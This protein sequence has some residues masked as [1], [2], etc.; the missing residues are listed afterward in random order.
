[1]AG[2]KDWEMS[3]RLQEDH[4]NHPASHLAA[5]VE[6]SDDAIISKDLEGRILSWNAGA[7]RV[8]GYSASEAIGQPMTIVLAPDRADEEDEILNHIRRGMRFEHFE[9]VRQRKDGH[10]IQV[11]LT[12]SPVRDSSG[13]IIGASHVAR[14]ITDRKHAEEELRAAKEQLQLLADSMP[15]AVS[16]CSRDYR[17]VWVSEGYAAWLHKRTEEIV[18][19]PIR[20]ILG[21]QGYEDIRAYM[22][23][24][25]AGEKVEYT[26]EVHFLGA[27]N[28]W[29]QAV[30]APTYERGQEVDGWIAV[31]T[32]ITD[33]RQMKLANAHFA[34]IVGSSEDAIIS[35]DLD[36]TILTWNAA[37]ERIYGYPAAEAIGEKMLLMVP[38]DRVQEEIEI[39][40]KI[41][42]GES[43]SHFETT[44]VKKGGASIDVSLTISP[45]RSREGKVMGVSHIA[46]D[47][48]ERKDVEKHLQ[49]TQRLESLGVL[50]GGIAHDFNN[51]LTG[52]LGN[53]SLAVEGVATNH[54]ARLPLRNALG[55]SERASDLTR[56]LLA[57]AGKGRFLIEPVNLSDLIR[58][59]SELIQASICKNVQLRLD[60]AQDLPYIEADGSQLQQLIMNLVIN[61]A[62]AIGEDRSGTVL[63]TTGIQDVD[64]AYL[65]STIGPEVEPGRYVS[66][67]V[68]DT[69]VG[70][71]PATISRIF[72][73]FFTTKFTG[74]GLGLAAVQG[75]VRGH[76]GTLK[77]Y[78]HP[79][80]GSTFKVLLPVTDKHPGTQRQPSSA[81]ALEGDA[82]VL[83][84]DDEQ[85]VRQTAKSMLER[86]GYM[87][88]L[89]E[90]GKE[91]LD[92][93][94][95]LA[96]KV[97]LVLLDMTMPVMSGEETLRNLKLIQ[98]E[99]K[100]LLSSGYNESEAIRRFTGK[101]LVG[102]IQ[103]PYSAVHL[104]KTV[105]RALDAPSRGVS[106]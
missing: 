69:G 100:V 4:R 46:R 104:A 28:R 64:E 10:S 19:K 106:E 55:A 56:Q 62:E 97:A 40:S 84:V 82:T 98:P 51:L 89:A 63:V 30:Y 48:T 83:V 73:P 70:M 72:D 2:N 90:N 13:A 65:L 17:Y 31:I 78:S 27:G 54:P 35:K 71:D 88:L 102:F 103:K 93:F 29:I 43:V 92:L 38:P 5:I 85:I 16:R 75:I 57:Y 67:E 101:G 11:S 34:A 76:K 12:I 105:R 77:V 91:G 74:R 25:L 50:A 8:Y 9:T 39:L 53:I 1:M 99:V 41:R 79:G 24:V 49:Q 95:L 37:A 60:L 15:A 44:R 32:D 86:Y 87:V 58:E 20:E 68:H 33:T 96:D 42:H 66:L 81:E 36:G 52:I 80:K 23:R 94:R 45:I 26:T 6:S 21:H 7:E 61:G 14:D 18:G 22:E 59:I 47:I 3:N